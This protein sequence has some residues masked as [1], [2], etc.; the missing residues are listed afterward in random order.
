[1]PVIASGMSL[2]VT[3]YEWFCFCTYSYVG[4]FGG[5][6]IHLLNL[7]MRFLPKPERA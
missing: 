5:I 4:I 1:M 3:K 2:M 6:N 7:K